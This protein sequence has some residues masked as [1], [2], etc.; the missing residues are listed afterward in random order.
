M[1]LET[2]DYSNIDITKNGPHVPMYRL[3]KD[4]VKEDELVEKHVRIRR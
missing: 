2:I 3:M 4:N 1:V